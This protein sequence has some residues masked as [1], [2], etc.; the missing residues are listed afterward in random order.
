ME[1]DG[2]RRTFDQYPE[3]DSYTFV[4]MILTNEEALPKIADFAVWNPEGDFTAEIL[5][6]K[7]AIL[8]ITDIDKM[9]RKMLDDIEDL[10]QKAAQAGIQPSILAAN[11]AEKIELFLQS[12]NWDFPYYQGDATV[13]KTI[14][15]SNPGLLLLNEGTVLKKYHYRTLPSWADLLEIFT[16]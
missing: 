9:D 3:D 15:R 11:S 14:I 1:K 7:Q 4:E 2:E 13:L 5:S 8:I 12:Q 6:G 10:F 16:R